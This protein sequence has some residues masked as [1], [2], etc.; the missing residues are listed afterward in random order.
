MLDGTE[1]QLLLDTGASKSFMSKSYYMQCKSLHFLPKFASKTQRIQVGNGQC[2]S[3]LFIIPFI[4]DINGHRFEIYTLASEIHENVE[5]VLGIKNMFKLEGVIN[6]RDCCAKFMNRSLPIFPV[7]CIVLKPK[8][9][10]LI[11]V[12]APFIGEIS[13]LA[14]VKI[15]DG[16]THRPY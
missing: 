2:M 8:E 7:D 12:K 16:G 5:L 1:W 9:Q 10:K 3:V 6:S 4:V 11:K 14:I 15:L 13:G